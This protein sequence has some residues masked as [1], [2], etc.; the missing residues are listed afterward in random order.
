MTQGGK[1]KIPSIYP[2]GILVFVF[3]KHFLKNFS[4]TYCKR[5]FYVV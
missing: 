2:E 5:V 4:F 1:T 3:F